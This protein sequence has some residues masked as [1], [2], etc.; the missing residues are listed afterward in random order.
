MHTP[1]YKAI[2]W[3]ARNDESGCMSVDEVAGLM[4]VCI[5]A[6]LFDMD[7]IDIARRVVNRREELG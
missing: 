3:I 6:D 1:L 2:D 5:I 7:T 4:T